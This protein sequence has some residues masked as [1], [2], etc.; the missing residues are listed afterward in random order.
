MKDK[1]Q[2]ALEY[3]GNRFNCSQALLA[4]FSD[5]LGITEE[6]A[7]KIGTQFGGGARCGELCGAVSGALMILGLKYGHYHQGNEEEKARAYAIAVDF[8]KR[9]CIKNGSVVCKEL[10]KYDL[11]KNEE[12]DII[13]KKDLFHVLCPQIITDAVEIVEQMILEYDNIVFSKCQCTENR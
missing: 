12:M 2:I 9:F 7:L 3:Y 6:L 13:N 8:N 5:E 1:K 4:T 11:T 10:L